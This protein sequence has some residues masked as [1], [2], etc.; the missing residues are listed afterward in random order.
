MKKSYGSVPKTRLKRIFEALLVLANENKRGPLHLKCGSQMTLRRGKQPNQV[1]V[2]TSTATL[3]EFT[4]QYEALQDKGANDPLVSWQVAE[5]LRHLESTLGILIDCR[6]KRQGATERYFRLELWYPL[7]EVRLNLSEVNRRWPKSLS[8]EHKSSSEPSISPFARNRQLLKLIQA[9]AQ[10]ITWQQF[11]I[12]IGLSEVSEQQSKT[13]LAETC[14]LLLSNPPEAWCQYLYRFSPFH[15]LEARAGEHLLSLISKIPSLQRSTVDIVVDQIAR[16]QSWPSGE[17]NSFLLQLA[18]GE[19]WAGLQTLTEISWKLLDAG[20][21]QLANQ[22]ITLLSDEQLYKSKI[23]ELLEIK[24]IAITDQHNQVIL[25]SG[26]MLRRKGLPAYLKGKITHLLIQGLVLTGKY[27]LA[28]KVSERAIKDISPETDLENWLVF[29]C[30]LCSLDIYFGR[31]GNAE[32]R[33][34]GLEKIVEAQY[35]KHVQPL[36]LQLKGEYYQSLKDF[37]QAQSYFQSSLEHYEIL[38]QSSRVQELRDKLRK[39]NQG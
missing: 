8:I 29:Q 37:S 25:L 39:I 1:Y 19:E 35:S 31:K 18:H 23:Q 28:W 6:S 22:L 16:I 3:A 34:L 26:A 9:A 5:T 11:A 24:Q 32:A 38:R 20:E 17:T 33:L 7:A 13:L 10:P 27:H 21:A 30:T 12:A 14:I 4:N 15:L 2:R 36:I